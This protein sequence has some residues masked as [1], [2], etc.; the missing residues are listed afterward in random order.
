MTDPI[1]NANFSA[2]NTP[3]ARKS[4]RDQTAQRADDDTPQTPSPGTP[5]AGDDRVTVSNPVATPAAAAEPLQSA[6]A[7]REVAAQL[8][9]LIQADPASAL[10]AQRGINDS[11]AAG[12][13]VQPA[14]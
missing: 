11:I 1:N 12:A 8:T 6:T 2:H 3:Q 10:M 5:K 14:A 4:D 13:L 7:A 9:Q